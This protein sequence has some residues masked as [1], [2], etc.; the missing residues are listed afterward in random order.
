LAEGLEA[1]AG[2]RA[3]YLDTRI[4]VLFPEKFSRSLGDRVNGAGTFDDDIT[5]DSPA[6]LITAGTT[7][8]R[9]TQRE[10]QHKTQT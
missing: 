5:R 8:G 7:A 3:A 6:T 2:P 10:S 4:G 9:E 1:V